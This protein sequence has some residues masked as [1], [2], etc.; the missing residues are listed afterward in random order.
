MIRIS[1]K[2][3]PPYL[4]S[5]WLHFDLLVDTQEFRQLFDSLGSSISLFSTM[6]VQPKDKSRIVI[7]EFLQVWQRY[8]DDLQQSKKVDERLYRF[9]FTALLTQDE[10]Y[11]RALDL[12]DDKEMIVPYAPCLQMQF[13]RF[14]YSK[15]DK[16]FKSQSF[17]QTALSWG[18]RLSYPQLFQY[19]ETRAVENALKKEKFSNAE[20]VPALRSWLRKQTIPTPFL[21]DGKKVVTTSRLGKNCFSWINAHPDLRANNLEVLS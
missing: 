11:I 4:A 9:F 3:A 6:G 2:K 14:I 15:T 12:P 13:H 17:G 21:I 16:S 7:E 1:P 10:S 18:V 19:P 8:I 5:K 20:L